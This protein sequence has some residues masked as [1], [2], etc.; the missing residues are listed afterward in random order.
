VSSDARG[1]T[2]VTSSSN[3]VFVKLNELICELAYGKRM[4]FEEMQA[5]QDENDCVPTVGY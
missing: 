1:C 2:R 4:K 3:G 5:Y